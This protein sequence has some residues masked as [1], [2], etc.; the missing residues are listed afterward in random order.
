[1]QV[2][3]AVVDAGD[4]LFDMTAANQVVAVTA[5]ILGGQV[6]ESA[7]DEAFASWQRLLIVVY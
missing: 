5:H 6:L 4:L 2:A 1:M 7:L 3:C